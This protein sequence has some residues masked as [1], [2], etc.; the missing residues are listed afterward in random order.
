MR[1]VL[2]YGNGNGNGGSGDRGWM[3]GFL[4]RTIYCTCDAD[5][6][7][8]LGKHSIPPWPPRAQ[9]SAAVHPSLAF[10]PSNLQHYACVSFPKEKQNHVLSMAYAS[11]CF[12]LAPLS[13][14]PKEDEM[15]WAFPSLLSFMCYLPFFFVATFLGFSLKQNKV[16]GSN[17]S[18]L[19]SSKPIYY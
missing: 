7:T 4:I 18:G 10:R 13:P 19:I 17:C 2:E 11:A 8:L 6:C 5:S 15:Q 16:S 12:Q 9:G 14:S 3:I 1:K